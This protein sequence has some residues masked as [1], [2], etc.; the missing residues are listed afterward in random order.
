ME[1]LSFDSILSGNE[2]ENL[3]E[4]TGE[5]P[6]EETIGVKQGE[7]EEEAS[8][9]KENNGTKNTTEVNPE[10]LFGDEL[11]GKEKPESVG[12]GKDKE[13]DEGGST[14]DNG[15]DTSPENFY[16]SIAS[17]MA[18]DGIF[19]NLDE[20]TV[21]KANDAESFSDLFEAEL[22]ARLDE[23][24]QR[25]KKAL[26]NGVE[27]SDIRKYE[28]TINYLSSIN[29]AV[30]AEESEKGEQL[31]YQLI[32]QDYL[33]RGISKEKADKM[34]RRSIDAGTDVEDAKEAL[35]SNKEYFQG[36]YNKLL[37]EAEAEAEAEKADRIKQQEKLKDSIL[38][39]KTLMGDT[40][41]S[42][43]VRK[44]TFENISKPVYKDPETGEYLTAIQKYEMEH[45]A[46]FLKYVSLFYTLTD[47]FKDFKSF[48]KGQVKKEVRKGL[49]E[50]EQTLN[51][52]KRNT[53]GSLKMVTN[54]REDPESYILGG[55]LKL[56]L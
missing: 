11:G 25:I 41:I 7:E 8:E 9:P 42:Q 31:R 54:Q 56:A 14:N 18:E 47:G 24:Q 3:F 17:A 4:E 10:D 6:V 51:N 29:D 23:T 38:K 40:E 26:D 13:G 27:P 34:A 16:S 43:D 21:K 1:G 5:A 19:P 39:D 35:Q 50:L 12:S 22:M 55:N 53:D 28:S 20:E 36:A 48:T 32:T 46:D 49:R 45:R 52:T 2:I 15:G 37:K 30:I 44:K 33:N